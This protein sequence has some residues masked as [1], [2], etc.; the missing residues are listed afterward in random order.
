[1]NCAACRG[2]GVLSRVTQ[3]RRRVRDFTTCEACGGAGV[4]GCDY[5]RCDSEAV[6]LCN[7]CGYAECDEHVGRICF[8]KPHEYDEDDAAEDRAQSMREDPELCA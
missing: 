8:C 5:P 1:M 6:Y 4:I 7:S 2:E 3:G